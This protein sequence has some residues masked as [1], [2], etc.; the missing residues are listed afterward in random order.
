MTP[1]GGHHPTHAV[2]EEGRGGWSG[3]MRGWTRGKEEREGGMEGEG[4]VDGM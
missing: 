3:G 1:H 2:G 4:T